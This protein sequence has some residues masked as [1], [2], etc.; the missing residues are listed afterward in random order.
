VAVIR[1]NHG[2]AGEATFSC[3]GLLNNREVTLATEI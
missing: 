2:Q 1:T 3:F